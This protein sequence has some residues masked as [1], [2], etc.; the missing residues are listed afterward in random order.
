MTL[1]RRSA[2][3]ARFLLACIV[4]GSSA[5]GSGG[6][7]A[8]QVSPSPAP[9]PQ[10]T[11]SVGAV[12]IDGV[13]EVCAP[14]TA[15]VQ[16]SNG[17]NN[18]TITYQWS[19]DGE[20]LAGA[21]GDT[22]TP[23]VDDFDKAVLVNASYT[24]DEGFSE[25]IAATPVT[26]R[27]A[28][29]F[30]GVATLSGAAQVGET[31][32]VAVADKNGTTTSAFT[33]Q[34]QSD[35]VNIAGAQGPTLQL[36]S[37]LLGAA[38]QVLVNYTDDQGYV[39]DVQSDETV[40][41]VAA[42]SGGNFPRGTVGDNDTVPQVSCDTVVAS[43]SSLEAMTNRSMTPG[44]TV[45]VADGTYTDLDLDFG[46]AG[47]EAEPITVAAQNPGEVTI[48]GAIKVRMSGT[49]V[50]LQGLI[51]K[52][53]TSED[54]DLLQTRT[55]SSNLCDHCRVTEISIIDIDDASS[56]SNKWVSIYGQH[57]RV[58]HSWFSGKTNE[59]ALMVVWRSVPSG[60]VPADVEINYAQMDHNY[61]GNRPPADGKPYPTSGDNGFEA[62][63]IGT[64]DSHS[65]DALSVLEHNYFERIDGESEVI[66][67]K[68]G[69]NTLYNNTIRDSFGALTLRHGSSATV[70][71]NFIIGDDHPF[72]S[73]IRVIDDGH[74]IVNNYIE[75]VRY[76]ATSFH[77]GIVLHSSDGSTSN[78]YQV[79]E[80]V[81]VANNTIVDS[82]N[83]LSVS[84]GSFSI[85]PEDVIFVNNIIADAIGPVIVRAD[86]GMPAS[87]TYAGNYVYGQEFSDNSSITSFSGFSF[88]DAQLEDDGLGIARPSLVSP[89]LLADAT[90]DLE[91][92]DPVEDDMDGQERVGA[93]NSGAD[94]DSNQPV[95]VGVLTP[96][97]VGPIS[98]T[99][100]A[101]PGTVVRFEITNHDFDNGMSGW[102][103]DAPSGLTTTQDET[104]SRG[105]SAEVTGAG[106]ISQTINIEPNTNYTLSAFT[107]GPARLG[108]SLG[109]SEQSETDNNSA[110][111]F[112]SVS[113]SSGANSQVTVFAETTGS[114]AF[115]DS[116]R[117]ISHAA[118]Q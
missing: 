29:N 7:G 114:G 86:D 73:G 13:P 113:F 4:V 68:S 51:F 71:H 70:S 69:N 37:N 111:R 55:S 99:P 104:Y 16:D 35:G 42:A 36:A 28:P 97:D 96:L 17:L 87:S 100:P 90:V 15:E 47:T 79:L 107:Q 46:G 2:F 39:E 45:C 25:N 115:F 63:R 48:G 93:T 59:G 64:S 88:V 65:E 8:P 5:C 32:E 27:Q 89:S 116:F 18:A 103:F 101:T 109:G 102:T 92:F 52:D 60:G 10:P 98:Y 91:G 105:V 1:S 85:E 56:S 76:T 26:I 77:G 81:F 14:L 6:G 118:A 20:D 84:G 50:V 106:R 74:R 23:T 110:Y 44:V 75:G 19:A 66:S 34:W 94:H 12:S 83:S 108:V 78:G 3:Q 67:N 31:L 62:V 49:Y 117:L 38:I 80:N 41:V 22:Y 112:T 58:D 95:T 61:F 53:G 72:A 30:L 21:T 11:N 9:G 57:T 40:A 82:I 43:M 54:G 33:Y 24:D